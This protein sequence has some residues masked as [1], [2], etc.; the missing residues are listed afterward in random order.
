MFMPYGL[1]LKR[2]MFEQTRERISQLEKEYSPVGVSVLDKI[3]RSQVYT[4]VNVTPDIADY[5]LEVIE[6]SKHLIEN[7]DNIPEPDY[8]F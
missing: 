6:R 5:V 1:A 4:S 7:I 2:I 8:S 3:G